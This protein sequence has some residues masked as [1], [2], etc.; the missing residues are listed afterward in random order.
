MNRLVLMLLV[1]LLLSTASFAVSVR[2][3]VYQTRQAGKVVFRHG[4]HIT[5]KQMLH[6]CRACH[7]TLFDLKKKRHFSMADMK[8][9]KSCGACHNGTVGFGLQQCA[10]CHETKEIVYNDRSTGPTGFSHKSHIKAFPDCGRCHPGIFAAGKNRRFTMADMKKGA[11][12]G[13]CHNGKTAFG[14]ADCAACHH[15]GDIAYRVAQTGPTRFSHTSH[16]VTASCTACHP[17]IYSPDR[18]NRN[19]DMA[20]MARGASCGACHNGKKAFP[21]KDCTTCHPVKELTFEEKT[22]GSV[23]FSHKSHTGLFSC[24]ECHPAPYAAARGTTRVTMQ[25]MEQGASCGKC[26]DGK[27]AFSASGDC[28]SCH[29]I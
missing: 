28:K 11:S 10:R 1:T 25:Q 8:R 29:H 6:N 20:A 23:A 16:L 12:C 3:Q 27:S 14:L 24:G 13:A 22:V 15:I 18:K 4:D 2:D 21:L 5:R 9:G 26:H 17:R 7:D 19:V